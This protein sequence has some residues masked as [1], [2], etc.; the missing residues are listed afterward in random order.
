M[1]LSKAWLIASKDLRIF[2][3]KRNVLYSAAF[4]PF[5]LAVGLP[6]LIRYVGTRHSVSA[7]I[8][9]NF[10]NAFSFFFVILAGITP[11]AIASYSLVGEKVQKSLE[12]LLAAPITDGELLAG[13]AIASF[14]PTIVPIYLASIIFMVLSDVFSS[15]MLGY[16]YYPNW[17]IGLIL[18]VLVPLS[19]IFSIGLN[20]LISSRVNDVRT[21]Q[22]YG[23]FSILPFAAVYLLTEIQVLKLT[24]ETLWIIAGI[25]LAVN[26][27]LF[28]LSARIFQREKILTEWK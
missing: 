8:L 4:I 28:P 23:Y 3:T 5:L 13:K 24:I 17:E 15:G 2:R 21:A 7:S 11:T 1:R 14:V 20:I 22:M 27:I 12:P 19:V 6:V 26:L 16:R 18:L 9:E 25:I 10:L